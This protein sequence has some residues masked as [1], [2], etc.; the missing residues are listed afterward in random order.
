MRLHCSLADS[1][2][3]LL[4]HPVQTLKPQHTTSA[5]VLRPFIK[6]GDASHALHERMKAV[7]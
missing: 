7:R 6:G 5:D 2:D 4:P 1:I 3:A